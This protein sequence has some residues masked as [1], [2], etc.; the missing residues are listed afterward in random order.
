MWDGHLEE[1]RS[2]SS[3][4]IASEIASAGGHGRILVPEGAPGRATDRTVSV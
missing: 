4:Q 1:D 2:M 3:V